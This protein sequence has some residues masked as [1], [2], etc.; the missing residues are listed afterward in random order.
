MENLVLG[1]FTFIFCVI[2]FYFAFK[3]YKNQNTGLSLTFIIAAAL[4]LRIFIS[5]D[6]HLHDW[7]EKY[8]A[9]TGKNIFEDPSKPCLYRI[10]A[11]NYD[12]KNWV[13]N[14]IWLEK[15]PIP[16]YCIGASVAAFGS[17]EFAVRLP[18]IIIG[19][20]AVLLTSL[21]GTRLFSE[22][23]GLLAASL[24]AIHGLSIELIGG[25]VSSDHVEHFFVFFTELAF[26]LAICFITTEKRKNLVAI[27]IGVAVGMA[28]LCK[29]FPALLVIPVWL[30]ASLMSRKF[31]FPALIYYGLLS[32][33]GGVIVVAPYFFFLST[34]Y[35]QEFDWVLNKFVF[36]Y[37]EPI[38]KHTAPWYY[39]IHETG[40]IFG[41]LIYTALLAGIFFVFKRE[42]Q[43]QFLLLTL[44]WAVPV[45]IFSFADTKR[46]TYIMLAAPAFFVLTAYTCHSLYST[47]YP[48]LKKGYLNYI[49]IIALLVL[50]I[51]FSIERTKLF[52]L[53][54]TRVAWKDQLLSLNSLPYDTETT[55]IFGVEQYIDA[56]FYTDYT[57]YPKLPDSVSIQK[58]HAAN[59]TLLQ[60][61]PDSDTLVR[62]IK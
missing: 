29:W 40:V 49:L 43:W 44:W 8:H 47:V 22:K 36:A 60:F 48:L 53:R 25:R 59:Y 23:V 5:L 9:L 27:S 33:L 6:H 55:L 39:Y 35:P 19:C 18:S 26:F 1:I 31:S 13:G 32:I 30:L 34:I 62:E 58:L 21:I 37:N 24:H 20:M 7:D 28:I 14:H 57:V 52:E 54:E 17:H 16:L 12:H 11:L 56:M 3:S 10:P 46:Y 42:K 2:L 51:R 38:E 41:E 4:S 50:P 61:T 45:A 15:G